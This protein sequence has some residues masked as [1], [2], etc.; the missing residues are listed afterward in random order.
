MPEFDRFSGNYEQILERSTEIFG[1][2]SEYFAQHKARYLEAVLRGDAR[3][4][5]LDFGCGVGLLCRFIA[6]L[7]PQATVHGFDVSAASV[8]AIDPRLKDQGRF[9][10][11]LDDLDADYDA[12]VVSN[13]MHHI[14]P[15]ERQNSVSGLAARLKNE[16][17]LFIFEHNPLNPVTRW[18][19]AHC[20]FDEDAQLLPRR[21]ACSYVKN[22]GLQLLR[23]D[24]ILF[25]PG[26]FS[27]L[28]PLERGLSW[29]P[30]G[31]QYVLT[32]G[33]RGTDE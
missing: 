22:A 27:W 15:D 3:R 17:R 30:L 29:C 12:I 5:I 25:F 1:A 14:R 31:A 13:V 2:G 18:V 21:E 23:R 19:V 11:C 6:M 24:Y 28:R 8:D 7:L 32:A 10:S 33:K 20:P 4:K 26:I 9:T 16:G